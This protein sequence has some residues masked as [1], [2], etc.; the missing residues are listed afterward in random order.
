MPEI[1]SPYIR[2]G[3]D[4][5]RVADLLV[6]HEIAHTINNRLDEKLPSHAGWFQKLLWRVTEARQRFATREGTDSAHYQAQETVEKERR[7]PLTGLL[8]KTAYHQD[9]AAL[10]ANI[11]DDEE[12][13]IARLDMGLLNY[14]NQARGH[15]I[16]DEYL[17]QAATLINGVSFKNIQAIYGRCS[18]VGAYHES[19]DEYVVMLRAKKDRARDVADNLRRELSE[20][21]RVL[22]L[23]GGDIVVGDVGN[24][25]KVD[26]EILLDIGITTATEGREMLEAIL[27]KEIEIRGFNQ[28]ALIAET[29]DRIADARVDIRKAKKRLR[30]LRMLL[31]RDKNLYLQIYSYAAKGALSVDDKQLLDLDTDEKINNWISR[32]YAS[33]LEN[34]A[35]RKDDLYQKHLAEELSKVVD[36]F[37]EEN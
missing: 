35:R 12:V 37:V 25:H 36:R 26:R 1:Q 15:G 20:N 11:A 33:R 22:E 6:A 5:G 31:L 10:Y 9:R 32:I 30:M 19:G 14:F 17:K 8:N 16:G 18:F 3:P 4:V 29:V 34:D 27:N 21:I 7:D 13:I 24:E 28:A 23:P 2:N